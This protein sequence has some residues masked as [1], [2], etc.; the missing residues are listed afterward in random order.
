[1]PYLFLLCYV[2]IGDAINISKKQYTARAKN[3]NI[4]FF[5]TAM[6]ALSSTT[7]FALNGFKVEIVPSLLPWAIAY[8]ITYTLAATGTTMAIS[9]GPLSLSMFFISFYLV[10]PTFCGAIFLG[11]KIGLLCYVGL[12]LFFISLVMINIKPRD[13]KAEYIKITLKW[14]IIMLIAFVS[15]GAYLAIQNVCSAHFDGK[16]KTELMLYALAMTL[17]LSFVGGIVYKRNLKQAISDP[18]MKFAPLCGILS[19]FQLFLITLIIGKIP[20]AVL[21]P[22]SAALGAITMYFV[23]LFAYKEKFSPLQTVGYFIGVVAVVLLNI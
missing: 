2:L 10:I 1:M 11:E 17:V 15:G 12:A 6:V 7:L 5:V 22:T 13:G 18:A 21:Y 16:Y 14:A 9:C 23:S 8:A 3:P 4:F 20:S 19:G